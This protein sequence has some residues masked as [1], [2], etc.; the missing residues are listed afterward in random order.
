MDPNHP[1]VAFFQNLFPYTRLTSSP[2]FYAIVARYNTVTSY[3]AYWVLGV[4]GLTLI[5][6]AILNAM[7]RRPDDRYVWGYVW[8]RLVAG[9]ILG[10]SGF[11]VTHWPV[12]TLPWL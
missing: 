3:S 9:V 12:S 8:I 5:C 10:I 4:T 2:K 6:L 7:H 1:E 11:T